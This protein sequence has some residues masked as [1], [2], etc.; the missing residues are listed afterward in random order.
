MSDLITHAQRLAAQ[1]DTLRAELLARF[2]EITAEQ[3][4]HQARVHSLGKERAKIAALLADGGLVPVILAAEV[5]G[6]PQRAA[7]LVAR[8]RELLAKEQQREKAS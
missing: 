7:Q 8:G 5:G 1:R 2:R 3:A 6:S 4:D